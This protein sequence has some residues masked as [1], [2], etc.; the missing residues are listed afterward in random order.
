[1]KTVRA[2]IIVANTQ[3]FSPSF[4]H[5]LSS[6][7]LTERQVGVGVQVTGASIVAISVTQLTARS[8]SAVCA[9]GGARNNGCSRQVENYT[10][11]RSKND[12]VVV[13]SN[14]CIIHKMKEKFTCFLIHTHYQ[15]LNCRRVC[16]SINFSDLIKSSQQPVK[17]ATETRESTEDLMRFHK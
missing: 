15:E 2:R 3:F 9:T 6:D 5:P 14:I 1:M 17:A 11:T 13:S 4:L 7:L 12:S 8:Y 10:L 16:G